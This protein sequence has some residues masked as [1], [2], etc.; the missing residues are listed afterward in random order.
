MHAAPW[1]CARS[2]ARTASW[3]SSRAT[4]A[5]APL[6]GAPRSWHITRWVLAMAGVS[7]SDRYIRTLC[8]S[9]TANQLSDQQRHS[10][11]A[12]ASS[13]IPG[14]GLLAPHLLTAQALTAARNY[15]LKHCPQPS[16]ADDGAAC[17]FE[18]LAASAVAAA[19]GALRLPGLAGGSL[20][21]ERERHKSK[22]VFTG[23]FGGLALKV[24]INKVCESWWLW[25]W[26]WGGISACLAR[27]QPATHG[28]WQ[29]NC[30]DEKP[31]NPSYT[32]NRH[33]HPQP[34]PPQGVQ[35]WLRRHPHRGHRLRRC[36]Q[37]AAGPR[38]GCAAPGA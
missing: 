24:S 6:T 34:P 9:I 23:V 38:P 35:P 18:A 19:G 31:K 36:T 25:R 27:L 29:R 37:R 33:Q 1:P 14:S 16:A 2:R 30:A 3:C 15:P 13:L 22:R 4:R 7:K 28:P 26:R 11:G 20:R 21:V 32:R 17:T 5:A 8:H 12:G 10:T